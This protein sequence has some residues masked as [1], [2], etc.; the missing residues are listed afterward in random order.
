[1]VTQLCYSASEKKKSNYGIT[2]GN[3]SFLL[4]L[5]LIILLSVIVRSSFMHVFSSSPSLQSSLRHTHKTQKGQCSAIQWYLVSRQLIQCIIIIITVNL[6]LTLAPGFQCRKAG[7]AQYNFSCNSHTHYVGHSLRLKTI[8]VNV[9]Q[10]FTGVE[11]GLSNRPISAIGQHTWFSSCP[12]QRDYKSIHSCN[13]SGCIQTT[14]YDQNWTIQKL[15]SS[16]ELY[17]KNIN[18]GSS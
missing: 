16:S 2:K 14:P 12:H 13:N 18:S 8:S 4:V 10:C 6:F 9:Q 3:W 1:M 17:S 7:A 15:D 5:S 11:C